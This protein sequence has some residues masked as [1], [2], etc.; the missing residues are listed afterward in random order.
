MGRAGKALKQTLSIFGI[1]QNQLA[2][3][4]GVGHANVSRWV[5]EVRDPGGET[6]LEIRTALGQINPDAAEEFIRLYLTMPKNE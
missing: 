3:A 5:N 1:S 4:M 6:I 2:A